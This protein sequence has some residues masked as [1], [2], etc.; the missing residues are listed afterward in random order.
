MKCLA[1]RLTV[2]KEEVKDVVENGNFVLAIRPVL[3]NKYVTPN[4]AGTDAKINIPYQ[5]AW[6]PKVIEAEIVGAF[7]FD[8][9]RNRTIPTM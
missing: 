8:A 5:T 7:F 9:K 3:T 6:I 4:F 2:E 1:L